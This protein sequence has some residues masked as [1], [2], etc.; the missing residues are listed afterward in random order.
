MIY[1][2]T[3]VLVAFIN[4]S[5]P[6]HEAAV[7]YL[8]KKDVEFIV[9]QVTVLELYSVFSRVMDV[10]DAE[11]EAL[12]EYTIRRSAAK[13]TEVDWHKLYKQALAI[14]NA[15]KLRTI[16]LLH[17]AAASLANAKIFVTFDKNILSRSTA[18]QQALG[19][20]LVSPTNT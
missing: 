1:L 2:D 20:Q 12:V 18:V 17:V 16:D 5:D 3:N 9:S 15:V 7:N 6:N 14:A 10:S 19:F 13:L 4:S 8:S 11:V